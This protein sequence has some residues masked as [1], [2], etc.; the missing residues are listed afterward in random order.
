MAKP[1]ELRNLAAQIER[2]GTRNF[3]IA[4]TNEGEADVVAALRFQ[5]DA[6]EKLEVESRCVR[7]IG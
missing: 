2:Y 4:L 6:L 5:A 7:R 1:Y 3:K